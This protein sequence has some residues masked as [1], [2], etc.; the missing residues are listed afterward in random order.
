MSSHTPSRKPRNR[1]RLPASTSA[2]S[3]ADFPL[4]SFLWPAKG[5][6][7]SQWLVVPLILMVVTV[8][9]WSTSLW[10]YS[11]YRAEPMHGDFEAP[12]TLAGADCAPVASAMVLLR[13]A[14]V[15]AGL[16]AF[17]CVPQLGAG[18]DVCVS[19]DF[20]VE[21]TCAVGTISI[22]RGLSS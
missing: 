1:H 6:S 14:V 19:L 11:G 21:L 12:A 5:S 8:F 10:P 4:A 3:P 20:C 17:D 9:R 2:I 18:Q 22:R 7:D 16:S 15:G 13:P